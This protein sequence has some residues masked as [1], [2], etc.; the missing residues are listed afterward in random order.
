MI[1]IA[2]KV[3]CC[4]CNACGDICGKNAIAFK[5]DNEGFWYPH[6]DKNLCIDC[7]LCDKVCPI[8]NKANHVKRYTEPIVFAAYTKDE[9]IRLDSTSGGIHSMLAMKMYEKNAYVGGAVYNLD[10][11]VSQIVD[12]NPERLPDIRSSKYLQS[13]AEG[14]YKDIRSLLIKGKIVF[15]VVVHARFMHFIII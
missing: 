9:A 8:Q 12:D 1:H 13:N 14:V 11:S 4:G 10:H 7:G 5:T 15:S 3:D 6:V 2:N